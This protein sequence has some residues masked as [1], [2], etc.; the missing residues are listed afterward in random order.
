[1]DKER[2]FKSEK[3]KNHENNTIG[4]GQ[5]MGTLA[6]VGCRIGS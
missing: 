5:L 4:A 6:I 1:M 2:S 3:F